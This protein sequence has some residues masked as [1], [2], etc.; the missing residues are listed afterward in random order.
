[1]NETLSKKPSPS[2]FAVYRVSNETILLSS[3]RVSAR[4]C[5]FAAILVVSVVHRCART[6]SSR[7]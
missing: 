1:M 5:E 4:M 3:L 2:R 6:A 7:A